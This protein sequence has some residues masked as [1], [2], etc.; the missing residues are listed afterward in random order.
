MNWIVDFLDLLAIFWSSGPKGNF[1]EPRNRRGSNR[2]IRCSEL[3]GPLAVSCRRG[4]FLLTSPDLVQLRNND[5]MLRALLRFAVISGARRLTSKR[6]IRSKRGP[7]ICYTSAGV[8]LPSSVTCDRSSGI[9]Y[10]DQKLSQKY[11][12]MS[13]WELMERRI[14]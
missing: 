11:I 2:L 3:G 14:E 8:H 13:P 12:Y 1:L 9:Q 6:R 7:C 5:V 4:R 10:H